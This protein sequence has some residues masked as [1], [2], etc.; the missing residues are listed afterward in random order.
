MD[1]ILLS[2]EGTIMRF[3]GKL[4]LQGLLVCVCSSVCLAE[5]SP[6]AVVE[7]IISKMKKSGDPK[8]MTDYVDWQSA[9]DQMPPSARTAAKINSPEQMKTY[10]NG[11]AGGNGALEQTL[12]AQLDKVPADRK[13]AAQALIQSMSKQIESGKAKMDARIKDSTY[14]VLSSK[15]EGNNATVLVESTYQGETKNQ[16]LP[17]VKRD[18]KWLLEVGA[19][20]EQAKAQGLK[21]AQ[22]GKLGART[23][24][25]Q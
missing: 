6:E 8:V 9:Y 16:E 12:S 3:Y 25:L 10:Y 1:A 17:M 14:R 18:G 5:K 22:Q 2:L 15:V 7:E 23:G 13:A 21:E 24:N 11:I 4:L 20:M 19:L